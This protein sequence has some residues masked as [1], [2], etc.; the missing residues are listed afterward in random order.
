[1]SWYLDTLFRFFRFGHFTCFP[2]L[3]AA[4]G[5]LPDLVFQHGVVA[6]AAPAKLF[7][8]EQV[9]DIDKQKRY[10]EYDEDD[11]EYINEYHL[12]DY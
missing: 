5:A 9:A 10:S 1:M 12:A 6:G 4:D 11:A 7:A 2:F 8:G 3:P